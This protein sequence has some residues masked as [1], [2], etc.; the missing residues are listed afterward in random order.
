M[1][2]QRNKEKYSGSV[3]LLTVLIISSILVVSGITVVLLAVDLQRGSAGLKGKVEARTLSKTCFEEAL[4]II[5]D[6]LGY[7]GVYNYVDGTNTCTATVTNVAPG[8]LN[9]ETESVYNGYTYGES[10]T[11]NTTSYPISVEN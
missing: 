5:K 3:G 6:D 11:I 7:T 10:H 1:E 4:N 8:I 9:V 2:N